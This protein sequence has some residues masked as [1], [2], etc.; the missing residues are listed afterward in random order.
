MIKRAGRED[1]ASLVSKEYGENN[2][3][4]F[5]IIHQY[6]DDLFNFFN[7]IIAKAKEVGEKMDFEKTIKANMANIFRMRILWNL[8]KINDGDEIIYW[9]D[10]ERMDNEDEYPFILDE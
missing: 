5:S 2:L 4:L 9:K 8:K 3:E 7:S 1:N 10:K 6:Y